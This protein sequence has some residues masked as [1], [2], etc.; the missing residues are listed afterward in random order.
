MLHK[1]PHFS[2][3]P[4]K[5]RFENHRLPFELLYR[6]VL[7]DETDKNDSVIHFKSTTKDVGLS[8]FRIYN[9]KD[10]PFENLFEEKY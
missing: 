4:K 6:N 8:F 3:S 5:L 10:H 7:H 9:K 1:V 2:L